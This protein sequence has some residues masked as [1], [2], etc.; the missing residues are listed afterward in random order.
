[1]SKSTANQPHQRTL[2]PIESRSGIEITKG[3]R[4]LIDFSSNDYLGLS[5]HEGIK[6]KMLETLNTTSLGSTGSRLLSGD[7]TLTTDLEK[8]LAT[9]FN[10]ESA[11]I[12]NTGFQLN[13]SIFKT[14]FGPKDL[15]LADKWVHASIIEGCLS[16]LATLKRFKHNSIDHL[17]MLLSRYQSHYE[18]VVIVT[19]SVFSMD[20]DTAPLRELVSLK[21]QFNTLLYV[22]EAHALGVL[23][24]S[25]AGLS[26][27]NECA[28]EI[29]YIVGTF[30][31]AFGLF[32]A[33]IATSLSTKEQLIQ[34]CK[35]FIYST[36]LPPVLISGID[37]ALDFIPGMKAERLYLKQLSENVRTI[38]RAEN[39]QTR[40]STQIVPV[41]FKS[42]EETL[43]CSNLLQD[44]GFHVLPIRP[45]TVPQTE[46]RVRL[47]LSSDHK[48]VHISDLLKGLVHWKARN[49]NN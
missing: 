41:I 10:K 46:T 40:G 19:E 12:F 29:D 42:L 37:A 21:K 18:R 39:F 22:D 32:G 15:I 33:V 47:S 13:H 43:S 38:L 34:S 7:Y 11:L 16:S 9:F 26:E 20:G 36:A 23:G 6:S 3:D 17:K 48:E 25:G 44:A 14:L 8:K 30:G 4:L 31:K 27:E 35:G 24:E 1:M 45:P 5:H 28:D 2:S 49:E